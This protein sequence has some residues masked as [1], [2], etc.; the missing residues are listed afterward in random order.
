M[1]IY[2]YTAYSYALHNTV[3]QP[4][5]PWPE[6]SSVVAKS[7]DACLGSYEAFCQLCLWYHKLTMPE[8]PKER[9]ITETVRE[10][11]QKVRKMYQRGGKYAKS[12]F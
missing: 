8:T 12:H 10:A 3:K 4:L 6:H 9:L 5:Q 2:D 11:Y 7:N 1:L